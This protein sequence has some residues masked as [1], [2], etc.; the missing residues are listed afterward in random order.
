M[1]AL[2]T[3]EWIVKQFVSNWDAES[4]RFID[5]QRDYLLTIRNENE[6]LRYL[7]VL[8]NQ[9]RDVKKKKT[10]AERIQDEQ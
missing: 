6:R 5:L 1:A 7:E 8:V 2:E 3:F 10:S 9:I 4:K